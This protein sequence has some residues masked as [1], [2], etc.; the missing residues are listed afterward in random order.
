[1]VNR[2]FIYD[3]LVGLNLSIVDKAQCRS[4]Y[5]EIPTTN[6]MLENIYNG[7]DVRAAIVSDWLFANGIVCGKIFLG[8][9][10]PNEIIIH[11]VGVGSIYWDNHVAAVVL[12]EHN[13]I[14]I[15]DPRFSNE[16]ILFEDWI[17]QLLSM[18]NSDVG[19]LNCTNRFAVQNKTR[20]DH[21]M[22]Y[23]IVDLN[24]IDNALKEHKYKINKTK[25]IC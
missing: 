17:G 6:L 12:L 8:N 7:C 5:S 10:K 16:I 14:A 1:M 19:W 3:R 20:F 4:V 9:N 15:L 24:Y 25:L 11:E 18:D 13:E 23:S 2:S 21:K 22:D